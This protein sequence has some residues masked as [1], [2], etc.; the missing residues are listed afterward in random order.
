MPRRALHSERPAI[1][2]RKIASVSSLE[3]CISDGGRNQRN[4]SNGCDLLGVRLVHESVGAIVRS[5]MLEQIIG[6]VLT[7]LA[8]IYL[9]YAMLRPEKF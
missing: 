6:L 1:C 8:L 9:V 5:A 2:V 4:R 7:V 3:A